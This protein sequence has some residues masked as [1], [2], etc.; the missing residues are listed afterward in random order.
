MTADEITPFVEGLPGVS[1]DEAAP[2]EVGWGDSFFS[3]EPAKMP[4][5][6]IVTKDYG[7]RVAF[8]RL[9]SPVARRATWWPPPTSGRGALSR[10]E[11]LTLGQALLDHEL[12]DRRLLV[13]A[14]V[15]EPQGRHVVGV[16]DDARL[17]LERLL[18]AGQPQRE[19]DDVVERGGE[20]GAREQALLGD[21]HAGPGPA[22]VGVLAAQ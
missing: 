7:D 17:Q 10:V 12:G 14:D 19:G 22:L 15:D 18:D 1:T 4:F 8:S 3:Y 6:T 13:R 11:R 16:A 2:A 5:A 21:V 20:L 9:D